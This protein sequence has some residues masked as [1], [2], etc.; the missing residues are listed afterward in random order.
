MAFFFVD[1]SFHADPTMATTTNGPDS[2]GE[3]YSVAPTSI[4]ASVTDINAV[5]PPLDKMQ[6]WG[7]CTSLAS[8]RPTTPRT[9][10]DLERV[11]RS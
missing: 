4:A 5:L 3:R 1:G 2:I 6:N 7:W 9:P 11:F 8:M 10:L